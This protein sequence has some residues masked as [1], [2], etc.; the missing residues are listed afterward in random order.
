[1]KSGFYDFI[2]FCSL[3]DNIVKLETRCEE[4]Q[5]LLD[6]AKSMVEKQQQLQRRRRERRKSSGQRP[7]KSCQN[8]EDDETASE[9]QPV[10]SKDSDSD[11]GP[12]SIS[13][14]TQ[15]SGYS[16]GSMVHS[17]SEMSS[18]DREQPPKSS[19][20]SLEDEV[21]LVDRLRLDKIEV[22]ERLHEMEKVVTSLQT[23][24]RRL[25]TMFA[26]QCS[27]DS[28]RSVDDEVQDVL[29]VRY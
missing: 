12:S 26:S 2:D 11:S 19:L 25:Q 6:E 14:T 17:D 23:E 9:E 16:S 3:C 22:E 28:Y 24:N 29:D 21:L 27:Q 8:S 7:Q 15:E 20:I 4:L 18:P 13:R 10:K 5:R 1:M